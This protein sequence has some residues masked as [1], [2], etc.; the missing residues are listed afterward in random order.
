MSQV[1]AQ[2]RKWRSKVFVCGVGGRTMPTNIRMMLSIV[3]ALVAAAVFYFE[4]QA[5]Q[6]F[7]K[8]FALFLSLALV[9]AVWLFPE[10]KKHADRST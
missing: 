2:Q 10:A 6:G 1:G 8:W 4:H 9:G 7:L 3:V 5:G